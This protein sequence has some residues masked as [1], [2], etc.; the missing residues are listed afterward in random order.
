M[1]AVSAQKE[2]AEGKVGDM[3]SDLFAILWYYQRIAE[4]KEKEGKALRSNPDKYNKLVTEYTSCAERFNKKFSMES[5]LE[6]IPKIQESLS[7]HTRHAPETFMI[8]CLGHIHFHK[9]LPQYELCT[10]VKE[11]SRIEY[12]NY[13]IA[14][15]PT[16]PR[17]GTVIDL[18]RCALHIDEKVWT[19]QGTVDDFLKWR[20]D[21]SDKEL[22]HPTAQWLFEMYPDLR[23]RHVT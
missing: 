5:V 22:D 9:K 23:G 16:T 13:L 11:M 10:R 14:E 8:T 6:A 17:Y 12:L 4:E 21:A 15:D 3:R 20:C 19:H 1:S 7:I 2:K 18:L